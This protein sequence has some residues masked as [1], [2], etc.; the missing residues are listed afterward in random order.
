MDHRRFQSRCNPSEEIPGMIILKQDEKPEEFPLM[1][2]KFWKKG[3]RSVGSPEAQP[4]PSE[5]ANDV[6]PLRRQVAPPAVREIS[7]C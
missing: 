4:S 5:A 2:D 3:A 1:L 6:S 7:S